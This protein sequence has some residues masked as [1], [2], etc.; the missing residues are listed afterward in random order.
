LAIVL[1]LAG[2]ACAVSSAASRRP[3]AAPALPT[4]A[5]RWID[6]P[7]SWADLRGQVVLLDVWT[8]G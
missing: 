8:F 4:D 2:T 6:G 1:A 7:V 5:R 3:A